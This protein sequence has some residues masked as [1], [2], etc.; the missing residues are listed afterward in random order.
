H[1]ALAFGGR[2]RPVPQELVPADDLRLDEAALEIRVDHAGRL[3]RSRAF[4]DHPGAALVLAGGEIALQAEEHEAFADQLV[5]AGLLEADMSEEL[6]ALLSGKLLDLG[7]DLAAD[8]HRPRAF[9][10]GEG[11][12]LG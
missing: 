5:E 9:L 12:D 10:L 2:F 6:L 1:R 4:L 7:L 11:A 8:R 3:G